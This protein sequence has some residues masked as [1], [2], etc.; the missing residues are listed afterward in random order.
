MLKDTLYIIT[1]CMMMPNAG[2]AQNNT[3]YSNNIASLQ[4]VKDDNWLSMPAIRLNS[5][6]TINIS[7]DDL[8]HEYRRYAYKIEH[9][10]ADWTVSTSLFESDFC[11]GFAQGNTIDNAEESI[12]TNTLYTHYSMS[13]PNSECKLKL[14]GN[15][16][17]TVYDENEGDTVLSACFMVVEPLFNISLTATSNTDID[18]N[19]QHQQVAMQLN[20]GTINITDYQ[21]ELKY[22]VLQNKRWET[23]RWN[24]KPQYV[25]TK[26]LAWSHNRAL[27]FDGGN[28]YHK[29]E[30]LS[31]DHSTLGIEKV[32]WD[33]NDYFSWIWT[34]MPRYNY[35][36]DEDANGAFY[37]RNSDNIENDISSDYTNVVFRLK[38]P[39]QNGKV[40]I[41]GVWTNGAFNDKYEMKY[42]ENNEEY[43][44]TVKLKQ[45]YY[46][47]QYVTVNNQNEVR[48]VSS[49]GN[50]YQT[51][52]EYTALVYWRATG[53][54]TDRLAAMT[55]ISIK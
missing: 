26:G 22:V 14:S 29:F 2:I 7:F 36:Y 13:I 24:V 52:N 4:V 30:T 35:V 42:D 6:E 38:A 20:Y 43:R 25:N 33:G 53:S 44:A 51:E 49:E 46:S 37:I 12:N 39:R 45:G 47:Y 28:E 48:P 27:I 18:T 41:N 9:C 55:T 16:K 15:Y 34:D 10:E 3:V 8:T 31:T 1:A 21:R 54:R 11:D 19:M 23:A 17:V 40:Y 50:F 5:N 32:E